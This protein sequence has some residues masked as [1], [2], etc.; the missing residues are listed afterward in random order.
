MQTLNWSR[1]DSDGSRFSR[2]KR[3]FYAIIIR[4]IPEDH[5]K[6]CVV[7]LYATDKPMTAFEIK[8]SVGGGQ[9]KPISRQIVWGNRPPVTKIHQTVENMKSTAKR[10][11]NQMPKL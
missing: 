11:E 4:G 8:V 1:V 5:P 9:I 6:D 10:R 7:E 2:G 3:D